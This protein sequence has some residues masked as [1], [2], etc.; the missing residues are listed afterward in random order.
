LAST[1]TIIPS[2]KIAASTASPPL[3]RVRRAEPLPGQDFGQEVGEEP[4]S[5]C[6]PAFGST[7]DLLE[8]GEVLGKL[9]EASLRLRQGPETLPHVGHH[10]LDGAQSFPERAL[11]AL[12]ELGSGCKLPPN[13]I[14]KALQLAGEELAE[15]SHLLREGSN[16][17]LDVHHRPP[18]GCP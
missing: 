3:E 1:G 9:G 6:A 18:S 17:S 8:G 16:L 15:L 14:G 5:K 10:P 7:Q 2:R 13:L 12:E 11:L 4:F